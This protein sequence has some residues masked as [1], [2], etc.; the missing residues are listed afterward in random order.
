MENVNIVGSQRYFQFGKSTTN[1][2]IVHFG[3]SYVAHVQIGGLFLQG[4]R[5]REII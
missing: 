4:N 1:Q 5:A 3:R 2:R